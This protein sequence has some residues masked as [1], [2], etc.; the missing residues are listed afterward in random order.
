MDY[1]NIRIFH[2]LSYVFFFELYIIIKFT[3]ECFYQE[4]FNELNLE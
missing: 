2:N 4:T 3:G 1:I